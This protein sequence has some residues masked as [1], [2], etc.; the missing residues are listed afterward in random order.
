M[1]FLHLNEFHSTLDFCVLL[2]G[3]LYMPTSE[4]TMEMTFNE[5]KILKWNK[6][7]L[8][9]YSFGFFFT[10]FFFC[11]LIKTLSQT[12]IELKTFS[13]DRRFYPLPMKML[14]HNIVFL[15]EGNFSTIFFWFT[16]QRCVDP[17]F[18]KIIESTENSHNT[19]QKIL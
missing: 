6:M 10:T 9:E 7:V 8:E 19:E 2:F 12:I 15:P 13:M 5:I 1:V 3:P 16:Y 17:L 18:T 4:I 14:E 11:Y